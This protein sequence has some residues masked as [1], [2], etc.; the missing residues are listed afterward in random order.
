MGADARIWGKRRIF[1]SRPRW[2]R[3]KWPTLAA[4]VMVIIILVA[5]GAGIRYNVT[6][7]MPLGFYRIIDEAPTIGS[8][9][10]FCP[11][12]DRRYEFMPA[13][14]CSHGEAPYIKQVVAEPW[15]RVVVT[16]DQVTVNDV[17]LDDSASVFRPGLPHAIGE[18]ILE[19]GQFWVYGAG[20]PAQSFDSRYF[21]P[22][23]QLSAQVVL[24]LV[25]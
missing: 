7:S 3:L 18:W 14:S 15:D 16:K 2:S 10:V 24:Q 8:V 25:D 6:E 1:T 9:I 4:A 13:G 21:G 5:W 20:R 19:P 23:N 12:V 22:V 17:P 11:P